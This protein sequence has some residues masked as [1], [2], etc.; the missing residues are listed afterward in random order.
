LLVIT[1]GRVEV[2]KGEGEKRT[3]LN[4]L[5]R[6]TIVGEMALVDDEYRSANVR[7]LESTECLLISR[8]SFH[9]L[10]RQDPSVGLAVM[11]VLADRVRQSQTKIRDL[12][13]K[14]SDVVTEAKASTPEWG[15]EM[16]AGEEPSR[17]QGEGPER[18]HDAER[19]LSRAGTALLNNLAGIMGA[20]MGGAARVVEAANDTVLNEV[21]DASNRGSKRYARAFSQAV[22]EGVRAFEEVR[23]RR[24]HE[25]AA[26][27]EETYPRVRPREEPARNHETGEG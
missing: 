3:T 27:E 20:F 23:R 14:V 22:D 19:E 15:R 10:L 9:T 7:A 25:R 12:E 1:S 16:E 26:Y 21:V 8:D 11:S 2:Y 17:R 18:L 5:E 4:V 13:R 6:G 24:G